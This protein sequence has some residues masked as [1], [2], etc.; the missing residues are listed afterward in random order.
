MAFQQPFASG[1]PPIAGLDGAGEAPDGAANATAGSASSSTRQATL[2]R[3]VYRRGLRTI[4]WTASDPNG[5]EL[6]FDVLYRAE[7][8]EDW[9]TLRSGVEDLVFTWD[10]TSAPDG[11]YLVRIV[12][13]DAPSNA[14]GAA[15]T[16][17]AESTP[18]D[19]DN[20]PPRIDVTPTMPGAAEATVVFE[21]SD[22]HSAV[23]RVEYSL[24]TEQ[25]RLLFPQDGI[26]D[27]RTEHF[28]VTV[29]PDDLDRLVLRATD[30][31]DNAS[32]AAAR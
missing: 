7:A 15:L 3:R 18:F 19:V 23:R 31:M 21:V 8:E 10:T 27:S 17:L 26:A 28:S 30:A 2:G 5:D 29:D 20:T 22:S 9:R 13:S 14:P 25:W 16:G 12:A 32:T 6:R 24:D 4:Q 11:T 1:D